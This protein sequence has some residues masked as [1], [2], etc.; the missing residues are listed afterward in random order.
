[1]S[2]ASSNPLYEQS[3]GGENPLFEQPAAV[4]VNPLYNPPVASGQ[5]VLSSSRVASSGDD[6]NDGI[7]EIYISLIDA[8]SGEP[9]ATTRSEKTGDFYFAN[10]PDG[11]Y[12]VKISCGFL[13]KK[14]YDLE[15][16][17]PVDIAG[18]VQ[19]YDEMVY[20]NLS[21]EKQ[22]SMTTRAGISTSRSNV[23]TKTVNTSRGNIK[24]SRSIR[25]YFENGDTPSQNDAARPGSPIG[26][27]I[28]KG[29]KNPGGLLR[30]ISTD[31]NGEF[32]YEGL[33]AGNYTILLEYTMVLDDEIDL[34]LGE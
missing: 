32:E 13:S 29:G 7:G 19:A 27:I 31:E 22:D 21:T 10:V 25:T 12:T 11:D 26:G 34:K 9:V 2:S 23:R 14:G 4:V 28:V 1:M 33:D 3:S 30:T 18:A 5:N 17:S 16:N 15:V 20:L 6:D 8:N 24:S